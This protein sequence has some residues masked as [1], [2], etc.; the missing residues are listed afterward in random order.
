MDEA[1]TLRQQ[2]A[3]VVKVLIKA[4]RYVGRRVGE[5]T[6]EE[7][8]AAMELSFEIDALAKVK[9]SET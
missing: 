5:G 6:P 2:L 1:K 3:S 4:N 9:E 8:N 7:S